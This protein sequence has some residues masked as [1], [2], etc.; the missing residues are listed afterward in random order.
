M[1][2][3]SAVPKGKKRVTASPLLQ[4]DYETN[5]Y[6]QAGLLQAPD[7]WLWDFMTGGTSK[8]FPFTVEGLDPVSSQ[9]VHLHVV[10]QGAS[11][12]EDVEEEHHLS[13]LVNGTP[14]GETAFGGKL[15]HVFTTALPASLLQEGENELTLTNVGDTGAYSFVFLDRVH[16]VFP[17]TSGLREGRFDGFFPE[18]GVATV[19]GQRPLRG[20]RDEPDLPEVADAAQAPGGQG[21]APG[22]GPAPLPPGVPRTGLL[23]PRVS[24]PLASTLETDDPPGGLRADRPRGVP[25]GGPAASGETEGP[26]SH[27]AGGVFRGDHLG[28]RPRE[29]FGGGDPGLPGVRVPRVDGR[30]P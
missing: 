13:V 10:F 30:R 12:A 15:A 24:K 11:D 26:G 21:A 7:I 29:A 4:A 20:G 6:Y 25:G 28:I 3:V 1:R 2:T 14:V 23:A 18:G 27:R 19:V 17:E 8:S 9:P 5:R 16:V 22:A